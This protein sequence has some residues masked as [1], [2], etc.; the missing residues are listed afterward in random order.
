MTAAFAV[1]PNL[2][3]IKIVG[4]AVEKVVE[5]AKKNEEAARKNAETCDSIS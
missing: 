3:T 5:F 1:R 2:L 4:E